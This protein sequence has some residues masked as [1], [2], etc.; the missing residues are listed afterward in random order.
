LYGGHHIK[1]PVDAL[2]VV[3]G[4]PSV[5]HLWQCGFSHVVALM[6]SSCSAKQAE[7]I[8][9]M[10]SSHGMVWAFTDG[11]DAGRRCAQSIFA[12][13][14]GKHAVRWVKLDEGKQPTDCKLAQLAMFL[15]PN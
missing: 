12:E 7:I 14:G 8:T 4:F 11:D 10:V 9:R 1:L 3:E 6:G 13:V 2:F 5:W 15:P